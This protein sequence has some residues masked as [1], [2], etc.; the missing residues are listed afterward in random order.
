MPAAASQSERQRCSWCGTDPMYVSY[1][2]EE[3]GV[4]QRDENRLFEMLVLEGAQAGLSWITILR[5]RQHYRERF[6]NFD[7]AM[8]ASFDSG[9]IDRL[10]RDPGIVRNRLKVESAVRNARAFV[11]L[12][13]KHG[14]FSEWL[15]GFAS[16]TPRRNR[17]WRS[18]DVPTHTPLSDRISK[19]LGQAGFNFV[20]S[21]IVYAYLQAVGI[22]DDHL[23]GCF[24]RKEQP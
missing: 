16:D 10:L 18:Q 2:D 4:P 24:K 13:D 6:A 11:A 12:Q 19:E 1:H 20:G 7:P 22:V 14:T 23:L 3:W 21:T 8:V 17:F 9:K 15:W 5:K